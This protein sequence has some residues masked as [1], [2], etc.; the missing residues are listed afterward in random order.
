MDPDPAAPLRLRR[1]DRWSMRARLWR[2][3]RAGTGERRAALLDSARDTAVGAWV[4]SVD[5]DAEVDDA[6]TEAELRL[7]DGSAIALGRCHSPTLARIRA[8]LAAGPVVVER[9]AD[10]R[11]CW[12]VYLRTATG[13]L[14]LL[15]PRLAVV[16]GGGGLRTDTPAP[17][18]FA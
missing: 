17:L 6:L 13:N 12:G 15:A 18:A 11:H 1:R 8:A 16:R 10:H 3:W 14:G 4:A 7:F 9:L 2:A 5:S